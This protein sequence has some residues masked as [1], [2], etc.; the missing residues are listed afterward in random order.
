MRIVDVDSHFYEP[1]D[2]LDEHFPALAAQLPPLSISD[3]IFRFGM[4]DVLD[5]I[6]PDMQLDDPMDLAPALKPFLKGL[7]PASAKLDELVGRAVCHPE[8][9]A[10]RPRHEFNIELARRAQFDQPKPGP[11][12]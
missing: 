7:P 10:R 5:A 6:P 2:W 9:P 11:L 8:D 12:H 4:S 3:F 1:L